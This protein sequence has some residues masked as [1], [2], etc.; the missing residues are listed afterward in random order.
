LMME[1]IV[2]LPFSHLETDEQLSFLMQCICIS[3]SFGFLV[4]NNL[5]KESGFAPCLHFL[6]PIWSSLQLLLQQSQSLWSNDTCN[7]RWLHPDIVALVIIGPVLFGCVADTIAPPSNSAVPLSSSQKLP[8]KFDA[9]ALANVTSL[10]NF[11]TGILKELSRYGRRRSGKFIEPLMAPLYA[12]TSTIGVALGS[13]EKARLRLEHVL[14]KESGG[15]SSNNGKL[16]SLYALS[17]MIWSQLVQI[18]MICPSRSVS[19][20]LTTDKAGNGPGKLTLPNE[21]LE[22]H[23]EIASR[24]VGNGVF[25]WGVKLCGDSHMDIITPCFNQTHCNEWE[26]V[27]T[28]VFEQHP[29]IEAAHGEGSGGRP[30]SEVEFRIFNAYPELDGVKRKPSVFPESLLLLGKTLTKLCLDNCG[31]TG[32]PLSIG[33]HLTHLQVSD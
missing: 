22:S 25:L 20:K 26:K 2:L 7:G 24:I 23:L 1:K 19:L 8:P 12:L 15:S 29:L 17:E 21:T 11:I 14:N 16:P 6:E 18:R 28:K 30:H 13:V 32:L 31:L 3:K 33:H 4:R 5:S 9:R 27:A 10:D